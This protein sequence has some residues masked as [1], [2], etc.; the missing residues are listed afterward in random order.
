MNYPFSLPGACNKSCTCLGHNL[1]SVGWLC[2]KAGKQTQVLFGNR[3]WSRDQ[4]HQH[5]I[6]LTEK[7]NF[8]PHPRLLKQNLYLNKITEGSNEH[9][10]LTTTDLNEL[11]QILS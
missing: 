9:S 8:R 6:S 4:Q 5:P 11:M 2:S 10:S 1:V 7:Q 3:V